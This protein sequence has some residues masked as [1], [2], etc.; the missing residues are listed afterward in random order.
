MVVYN[1]YRDPVFGDGIDGEYCLMGD[2]C[3]PFECFFDDLSEAT[4]YAKTFTWRMAQDAMIL[5]KNE[6]Y[7]DNVAVEVNELDRV[8]PGYVVMCREWHG[9]EYEP[10]EWEA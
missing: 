5:C 9:G 6:G 2:G 10:T 8:D 1:V 3:H 4:A 7:W